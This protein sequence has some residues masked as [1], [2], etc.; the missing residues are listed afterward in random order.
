MNSTPDFGARFYIWHLVVP[1]CAAAVL[2]WLIHIFRIDWVVS[3]WFFDTGSGKFPLRDNPFFENVLH[4]AVKYA[5]VA[6]ALCVAGLVI[7]SLFSRRWMRHRALLLFV[8]A[9]MTLSSGAVSFLKSTTGQH[10]P[11]ELTAYDG[12]MPYV[13]LFES[14]PA[15][16]PR[17]HCW[18][19]GH[20]S[21]GFCLF[22]LYFGALWMRRRRLALGLLA[23][24]LMMGFGL[25]LG[26]V[27]QGVH[28]L[29]HN[30]WSAL[31]CWLVTLLL[32][33]VLR[34]QPRP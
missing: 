2:A 32:F 9:A 14:R 34:R 13:G 17:G 28:F 1:F 15:G 5:V 18:P 22:A 27:A 3:D 4:R 19:G 21:T 25:G 24:S 33:E 30:L 31:A 11:Y 29:S 20:A 6:V 23:G 12:A 7:L 26:R 8:L 10:C 16:V